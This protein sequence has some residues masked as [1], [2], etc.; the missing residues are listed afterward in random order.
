[1]SG[2]NNRRRNERSKGLRKEHVVRRIVCVLSVVI[3]IMGLIG[4]GQGSLGAG[5]LEA[6]PT[7]LSGHPMVGTWMAETPGGLALATFA[8]D[9]SVV[10]ALQ[11]TQRGPLGVSAV[12]TEV[13]TWEPVSAQGIHFTAVQ[14]LSNANGQ[15]LGTI[16]IDGYPVASADGQTLLDTGTPGSVTIRDAAHQV[17]QV[18]TNPPPVTGVRMAV[19]APGFPEETTA[20]PAA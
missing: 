12:S 14:I 5:A 13:G 16:T 17:V 7:D 9:G 11:P 20:T 10:M 18:V 3:A 4:V 8:A 2:P 6:T 1:M 15:F 19:G